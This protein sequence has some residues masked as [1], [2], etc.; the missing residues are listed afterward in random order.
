MKRFFINLLDWIYKK[1]C[2]FCRSSKECVKMCS[3]CY[4]EME[5]LSCQVNRTI[6]GVPVYCAG[7]YEKNLQ[8]LIKL[9]IYI[10]ILQEKFEKMVDKQNFI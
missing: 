3:S 4:D 10:V 7:V 6:D 1:K 8:K 2:Y 5:H 9:F